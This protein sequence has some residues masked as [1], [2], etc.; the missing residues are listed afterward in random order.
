MIRLSNAL[1]FQ[2]YINVI[3]THSNAL[4]FTFVNMVDLRNHTPMLQRLNLLIISGN[5]ESDDLTLQM[6]PMLDTHSDAPN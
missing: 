5:M 3:H 4:G 2:L 6:H 1:I